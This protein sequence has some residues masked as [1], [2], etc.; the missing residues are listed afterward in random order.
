[1]R[2][3]FETHISREGTN[4]FRC[5]LKT[6]YDGIVLDDALIVEENLLNLSQKI[7]GNMITNLEFFG[8]MNL[9]REGK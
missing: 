2:I 1:M 8:V 6:K 4:I 5:L 9:A 3:E 7:R